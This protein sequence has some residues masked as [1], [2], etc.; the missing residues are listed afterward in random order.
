MEWT[1]WGGD[2][3]GMGGKVRER[4][5]GDR[6]KEGAGVGRGGEGGKEGVKGREREG[7]GRGSWCP[8]H[9]CLLRDPASI[10][11]ADSPV[12]RRVSR[13][14]PAKKNFRLSRR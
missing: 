5:G 3:R 7:V 2:G 13:R 6:G 1:G 4:I 11:A 10:A 12:S 8:P 14:P 9:D